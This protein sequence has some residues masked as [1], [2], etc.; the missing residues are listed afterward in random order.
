[1]TEFAISPNL[2][3]IAAFACASTLGYL[4]LSLLAGGDRRIQTRLDELSG[5]S[6]ELFELS[7]ARAI[8]GRTPF[9]K[10]SLTRLG[11]YVIPDNEVKQREL[12]MRLIHAGIYA[13]SALSV[14]AGIRALLTIVPMVCGCLA[15]ASGLMSLE[16]ATYFLAPVVVLGM[17]GPSFW[18]DR[19][20]KRRKSTFRQAIPDFL[21]LIVACLESGMTFESALQ[22]VTDEL[23]TAH[24]ALTAEMRIVQREIAVGRSVDLALQN[25]AERCGLDE[26]KTIATFAQQARRLGTSMTEP[27]RTNAEMLRHRREQRAEELAHAAS[28]KILFPTLFFI[29]PVI[30][31][32]LVGPA[33]L[34]I[35][36]KLKETSVSQFSSSAASTLSN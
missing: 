12:R 4:I 14:F 27:L 15:L 5:N 13:P 18:L 32:I 1:M 6:E 24:P 21:D 35:K 7:R 28:V 33:A 16:M 26:A 30:V 8:R 2:I 20:T 34:E 19:R 9:L 36:E 31:G 11:R 23:Q 22:R 17:V 10:S 29:F 25:F 3:R